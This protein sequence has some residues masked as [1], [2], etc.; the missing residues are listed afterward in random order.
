MGCCIGQVCCGFN[1]SFKI[2]VVLD[3]TPVWFYPAGCM[4]G[5]L[6]GSGT[7]DSQV[8]RPEGSVTVVCVINCCFIDTQMLFM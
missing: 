4:Y 7:I 6:L 3:V 5:C 1:S 2:V 8:P